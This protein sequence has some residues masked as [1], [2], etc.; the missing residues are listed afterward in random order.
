MTSILYQ[1]MVKNWSTKLYS[2]SIY[3]LILCLGSDFMIEWAPYSITNSSYMS[4]RGDNDANKMIKATFYSKLWICLILFWQQRLRYWPYNSAGG[5]AHHS[6]LILSKNVKSHFT[7]II[8]GIVVLTADKI[9]NDIEN[10]SPFFLYP[11]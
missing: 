8:L 4:T 6:F 11:E 1:I 9:C 2:L 10:G 5:E 7:E 3:L